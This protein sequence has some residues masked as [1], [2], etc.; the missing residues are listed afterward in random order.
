MRWLVWS[1]L[2]VVTIAVGAGTALVERND[3]R[4]HPHTSPQASDYRV[5]VKLRPAAGAAIADGRVEIS[6]ARLQTSATRLQ[7]LAART[8]LSLRAQRPITEFMHAVQIDPAMTG[9]TVADTL[10][11]L[12][13]DPQ[14]EYAELDQRRYLHT[15]PNDPQYAPNADAALQEYGQW[16]LQPSSSTQPSAVDAQ[17][18]WTTTTGAGSSFVIADIDS[19]VAQDNNGVLHPDLSGRVLAGYCFISD[20]FTANNSACPGAGAIDPGDWVT[21]TDVANHPDQCGSGSNAVEVGPSTWHGTR[22]AGILGAATNNGIGVAGVTWSGMILPVR[23]LGKCGGSDSDIINAMLW[24]GGIAVA[25][26][27]PN[28]QPAKI[29]NMSLGGTGACPQQYIDAIDQLTAQGVLIVVSAGNEEGTPVDAPA[30]CPGVAAIAGLR[31]AGTKVGFSNI[32]T[33]IALSAPAGNCINT[34]ARQPCLYTMT[35]ATNLGETVPDASDYTGEYVCD[36]VADLSPGGVPTGSY[37]GCS[38]NQGQYRTYNVGTSFAAPTVSGIAALMS[39]VNSHLNSCQL[40]SRLQEGAAAFPTSSIG[41][42]TQPPACHVPVNASDVQNEC[43]CNTQTCGAGMANAPGA[44]AAA[45]RPVAAMIAPATV[46][47]G[48]SLTLDG[49]GSAA[50]GS[51]SIASYQWANVSGVAATISNASSSKATVTAPSCGIATVSLTVTDSG[52]RTDSAQVVI[53][54]NSATTSAPAA[55]GDGCSTAPAPALQI[56][57]CPVSASV[58]TGGA[59]ETFDASLANTTDTAVTWEV[60]GIAGGNSTVGTI[61]GSGVYTPPATVPNPATVDVT[62]VAAADP[63]F[64]AAAQVT[65]SAPPSQGGGGGGGGALDPMGLIALAGGAALRLSSRRRAA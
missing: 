13:A 55:A 5:I 49:S 53:T 21:S 28:N 59:G 63:S 60:N 35:T 22:V 7:A 11:R 26:A 45:M 29:I 4:T 46:S 58:T 30:N 18:A 20:A 36:T 32:G 24:A 3:A 12:R 16:Y 51:S 23:A 10:S 52:G 15:V 33:Q 2:M 56:A 19:G 27:P 37:P 62:A 44:L 6:A 9:Q 8:G 42:S 40:I 48:Q 54:P 43:I 61:S 57:V 50:A 1:A 17:D 65:I 38:V 25:G 47:A 64:T 39:A 34:G 41:A 31:Q 14:V